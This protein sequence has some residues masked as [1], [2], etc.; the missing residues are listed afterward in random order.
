MWVWWVKFLAYLKWDL[1][2]FF[3]TWVFYKDPP[4]SVTCFPYQAND[5]ACLCFLVAWPLLRSPRMISGLSLVWCLP[6]GV[7]RSSALSE[8]AWKQFIPLCYARI[9]LLSKD[10]FLLWGKQVLTGFLYHTYITI[11]RVPLLW[12]LRTREFS[13]VSSM[14]FSQAA[15]ESLSP[16]K[17]SL[18]VS[19]RLYLCGFFSNS[20]ARIECGAHGCWGM[21][22]CTEVFNKYCSE[23]DCFSEHMAAMNFSEG[24]FMSMNNQ[25]ALSIF[26]F[27]FLVKL[28]KWLILVC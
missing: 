7:A 23:N 5:W 27:Q 10:T 13:A 8:K 12:G 24:F 21:A 19:F 16:V 26:L 15:W 20:T 25:N 6:Q 22:Q 17:P 18:S 14:G 3:S 2:F 11:L 1:L 9:F 4:D 28:T